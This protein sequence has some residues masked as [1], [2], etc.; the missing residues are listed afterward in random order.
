MTS[1]S[2]SSLVPTMARAS[3]ACAVV[4]ALAA[5]GGHA[6]P[7]AEPVVT[8][9]PAPVSVVAGEQIPRA[10]HPSLL[11]F[12]DLGAGTDASSRS[13]LTVLK[14]IA[15]QFVSRGVLV[16]VVDTSGL[17]RDQ[18]VNV[19]YDWDLP[20]SGLLLLTGDQAADLV[21]AFRPTV[22]D[23]TLVAPG[24]TVAA[25]WQ[26]AV[27]PAQEIAPPLQAFAS[28]TPRTPP[29]EESP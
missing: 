16:A 20:G 14:S 4:S 29:P 11:S 5:C 15:T 2:R 26:G 28:S 23:T 12:L 24:G 27:A 3:A 22:P 13:Q 7:T 1:S 17:S 10:G 6:D 9:G 8:G 18:L 19:G 21:R 25:R